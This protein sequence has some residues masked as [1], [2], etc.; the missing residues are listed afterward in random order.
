MKGH[1]EAVVGLI[2]GVEE[3]GVLRER[4]GGD[5]CTVGHAHLEEGGGALGGCGDGDV[6]G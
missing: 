6:G 4:A 5:E 2:I 3:D 1:C